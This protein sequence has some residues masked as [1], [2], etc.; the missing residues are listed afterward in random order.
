MTIV[1]SRV[2]LELA[3]L[4]LGELEMQEGHWRVVSKSLDYETVS[5]NVD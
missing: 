3:P 2:F 5:I 1:A 4:H